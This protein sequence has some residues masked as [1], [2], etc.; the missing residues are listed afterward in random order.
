FELISTNM[1]PAIQSNLENGAFVPL[2]VA[3]PARVDSLPDVPTFKEL[4]YPEANKMSVFGFF[5]PGGTPEAIVTKLNAALND[6]VATPDIQKLLIDS[7][8]VPAV[9][10]PQEFAKNIQL[11]LDSNR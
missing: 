8:N 9:S 1:S 7:S 2:A 6:V 10:T 3:A 11:E 4:G 5:A